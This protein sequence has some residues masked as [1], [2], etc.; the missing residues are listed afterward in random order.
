MPAKLLEF[1]LYQAVSLGQLYSKVRRNEEEIQLVL[2]QMN[3]YMKYLSIKKSDVVLR[4]QEVSASIDGVDSETDMLSSICFS[5]GLKAYRVDAR[6]AKCNKLYL[7]GVHAILKKSLKYYQWLEEEGVCWFQKI[8]QIAAGD[9][10]LV[11]ASV[12]ALDLNEALE[13][14]AANGLLGL[15]GGESSAMFADIE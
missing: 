4:L 11:D 12:E 2:G 9:L 6:D 7:R 15:S 14:E 5:N 10:S 1:G 8:P 3:D 13:I